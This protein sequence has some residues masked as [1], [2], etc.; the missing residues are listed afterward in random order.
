MKVRF[1]VMS[2]VCSKWRTAL[3]ISGADASSWFKT[4]YSTYGNNRQCCRSC[5]PWVFCRCPTS[6]LWN[7]LHQS[8]ATLSSLLNPTILLVRKLM[9]FFKHCDRYLVYKT[10]NFVLISE[11][12]SLLFKSSLAD[13]KYCHTGFPIFILKYLN[14]KKTLDEFW[15]EL[16]NLFQSRAS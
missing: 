7:P 3:W 9:Q 16:R 6:F 14:L 4:S 15:W 1:T 10:K 11:K 5:G 8:S 2:F 12:P 13:W